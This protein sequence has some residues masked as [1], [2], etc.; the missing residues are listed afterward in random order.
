MKE[1]HSSTSILRF[2]AFEVNLQSRQLR[3]YGM[4]IRLERKPF[5][6]LEMLIESAGLVV[7]RKALRERLWPDTHVAFE[8]GLNTAMNKLRDLLGDSAENPRFVE[9]VPHLGYRFIAP[10]TKAGKP[11]AKTHNRVITALPLERSSRPE[12]RQ[13]F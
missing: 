7:N 5:L 6:I 10:V 3:K 8:H 11:K 4:R 13:S 9:T 1:N 2:G 12:A